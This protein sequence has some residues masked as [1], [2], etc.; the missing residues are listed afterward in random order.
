METVTLIGEMQSRAEELRRRGTTIGVVPTMGYLHDGHLSLVAQA[1]KET[2]V[3]V[4][5]LFVNPTQFGPGEDFERYPRDTERDKRLASQAGTDILFMPAADEMYPAGFKTYVF[6]EGLS[7]VLEGAF[8]PSHFRGVTTVVM[9][10]FHIVKPHVAVFGQKDAQQAAIISRMVKD[11]NLDIRLIIA[12]IVRESDG[13]AMSS[14]NVYLSPEERKNA[15]ALFRSLRFAED[16]VRKGER[17][18][19]TIRRGMEEILWNAR[20]S[21]VD[22]IAFVRPETFE[23]VEKIDPPNILV[24]LAVRFGK[25]RL[26]DNIVIPVS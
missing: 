23:E 24:A 17:A 1:R 6:T 14:R 22:Y 26:I 4:T 15:V 2:D 18:V 11:M 16:A 7:T 5:T 20:V 10:L 19:E 9:K 21:A 13:L 12:P 3:V 8:R 25:T